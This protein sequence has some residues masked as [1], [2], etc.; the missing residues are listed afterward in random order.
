MSK[1][2]K[3]R[4]KPSPSEPRAQPR[5][6]PRLYVVTPPLAD[7]RDFAPKLEAALGAADVACLLLMLDTTD[8]AASRAIT[9][10]LAPIAERHGAALM[11]STAP[12]VARAAGVDGINVRGAGPALAEAL[13]A[14]KPDHIVGASGLRSRHDAMTAGEEDIDY[15]MFGDPAPDGWTPPMEDTLDRVA[16]WAEIFNV[17]CVG[18]APSLDEITP[19]VLAGADFVALGEAIWNDPRGPAEAARAAMDA[20][21]ASV[22]A[23]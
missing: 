9:G 2:S 11:L 13:A 4:S 7:A 19:L 5:P 17:P 10:L 8:A 18:F 16:W 14:L 1:K 20:L 23:A 21:R 3:S 12:A 15:L 6:E 22:G